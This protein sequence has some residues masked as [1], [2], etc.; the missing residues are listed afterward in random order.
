MFLTQKYYFLRFWLSIV[1]QTKSNRYKKRLHLTP[2]PN[3]S[4]V[5]VYCFVLKVQFYAFSG[6]LWQFGP[7][8]K[9]AQKNNEGPAL[10]FLILHKGPALTLFFFAPWRK[11]K[12]SQLRGSGS[13]PSALPFRLHTSPWTRVRGPKETSDKGA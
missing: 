13:T 9:D 1:N 3:E 5:Y 8:L 10:T 6:L 11:S 4:L 7:Q 12:L 2:H